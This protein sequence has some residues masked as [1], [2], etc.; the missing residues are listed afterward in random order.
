MNNGDINSLYIYIRQ[1]CIL[2]P[3]DTKY[4]NFSDAYDSSQRP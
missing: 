3:V 2:L 1:F 4:C